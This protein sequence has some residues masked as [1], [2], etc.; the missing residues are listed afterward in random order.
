[1]ETVVRSLPRSLALAT[2]IALSGAVAACGDDDD[3]PTASFATPADGASVAGG[4]DVELAADGITIEEAGE[5][6]EGAGHFHILADV[7][8]TDTGVAIAKDADHVHL[9]KGQSEGT[10]YLEPGS[11]RLCVQVGDGEH[12]ALDVSDTIN[13]E[14]GIDD[15]DEWCQVIGE[16]DG[17][18]TDTDNSSDDFVT[19]QPAY[20]NIRRLISQLHDRLDLVDADQRDA[21]TTALDGATEIA[22]ILATAADEADAEAQLTPIFTG[23]DFT[24][25]AAPWI[26]E[27]CDVSID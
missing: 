15:M 6:R 16:V 24:A 3:G 13:I 19:K 18:F 22:R 8:C 2:A 10:I 7:D 26:Q 14:V 12:H 27:T 11:H 9:G 5:V 20:E 4:V 1:M 17:L 21:V 25:A 23:E